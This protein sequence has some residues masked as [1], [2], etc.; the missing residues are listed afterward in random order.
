MM[1]T[2]LLEDFITETELM[3]KFGLKSS[4]INR[5]RKRDTLPCYQMGQQGPRLYLKNEVT[6]YFLSCR[7][8]F[9]ERSGPK[10]KIKRKKRS[11]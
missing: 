4:I 10:K 3:T 9:E 2:T 11:D 5:A 8:L 1:E 7:K 6:D